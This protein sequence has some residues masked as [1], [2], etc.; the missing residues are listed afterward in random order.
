MEG[1][2][3][4]AAALAIPVLRQ[5]YA[6]TKL[7]A[8]G[9]EAAIEGAEFS[10]PGGLTLATPNGAT[11]TGALE[12]A[13][14]AAE[15]AEGIGVGTVT[16]TA[17]GSILPPD[18]F[19]SLSF[20]KKSDGKDYTPNVGKAG[21]V[22]RPTPIERKIDTPEIRN[23]FVKAKESSGEWVRRKGLVDGRQTWHNEDKT[24]YYQTTREKWE[25]EVYN[26]QGKHMGVIKPSDGELRTDLKVEGRSINI[27]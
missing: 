2:V 12:A 9:V 1:K 25:I 20:A 5:G 4:G 14:A 13:P 15:V 24:Q 17:T 18:D 19:T 10:T 8:K 23:S 27:K 26:K 22:D 6:V 7:V 3:L 11:L 21:S 16:T